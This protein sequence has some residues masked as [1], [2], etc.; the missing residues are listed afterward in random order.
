M[1]DLTSSPLG[2]L[3]LL[4]VDSMGLTPETLADPGVCFRLAATELTIL[5]RNI[6]DNPSI[7]AEVLERGKAL[8]S[9][10]RLVVEYPG[11]AWWFESLDLGHQLWIAHEGNPPDTTIWTL[12]NNPPDMWERYA[13]KPRSHQY[14]STV[15]GNEVSILVSNDERAGDFRWGF[16]LECWE[17]QIHSDLRVYEVHG[18]N[19]WHELCVR[20]PARGRIAGREEDR[21]VPNWGAAAEDWDS[22]HLSFGGLLTCEQRLYESDGQW[23]KHE[24]WHAETTYWFTRVEATSRR[25]PNHNQTYGPDWMDNSGL[26]LDSIFT[27][28]RASEN[29]TMGQQC[30]GDNNGPLQKL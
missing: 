14:T 24:T 30:K 20:Y 7:V 12:P 21:V 16:P 15:Y 8:V 5:D 13:Q 11:T 9:L 6:S 27:T 4:E 3:F 10:A 23:S 29:L 19:D 26:H 22:V 1:Q 18:P 25:L 28:L 17:L 2:C